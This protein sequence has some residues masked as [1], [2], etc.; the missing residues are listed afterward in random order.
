[1]KRY[2]IGILAL[3]AFVSCSTG[4]SATP[5]LYEY[6]FNVD[7]MIT[8]SAAPAGVNMEAFDTVTG[9]G[10]ITYTSSV[11]GLH[12]FLAYF[13][14]DI[15]VAHN[16]FYN[17]NGSYSGQVAADQSWEIDEPFLFGDI[18]G[19]F[20]GGS[21]DNGNGVLAGF[22]EDVAMAMGWDFSLLADQTAHITLNL[23]Q[24]L[25][26]SGFYLTQFDPDSQES[27]YLSSNL[28]IHNNNA[29]VPEPATMLL[30]GTGL[31][32]LFGYG[33]KKKIV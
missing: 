1:M 8:N 6:G 10:I 17:E 2:K 19:N 21:L 31:M 5:L 25:P 33:R 14:H 13:D 20:Q 15:D 26:A 12:S 4:A 28:A 11:A 16:G 27:L 24:I 7:G 18:Y 29:P 32:G 30:M 22:E 23:S 3:A 9:L